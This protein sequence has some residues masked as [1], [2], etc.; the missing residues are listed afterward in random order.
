MATKTYSAIVN[1]I[2]KR[3]GVAIQNVANVMVNQLRAYL[4]EDF[5]AMYDP[6]KYT[7]TNQFQDAPTYEMLSA[8][9]AKIFIDTGS[10]SYRTASGDEV[11]SLAALGFHGNTSIFRPGFFWEDFISWADENAPELLKSELKKQGLN[12]K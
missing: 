6:K 1:E 10:M 7:R 12:I 11:T 4:I 9:M 2:N 5:Y 3:A 8:N